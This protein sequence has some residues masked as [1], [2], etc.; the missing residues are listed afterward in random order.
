MTQEASLGLQGTADV[1]FSLPIVKAIYPD[2]LSNTAFVETIYQNVFNRPSDPEGSAYWTGLMDGG[3]SRGQLVMVMST[4][5]LGV[6]DGTAGKDYFQDRIDWAL[7][8]VAYQ[9][10]EQIELTPTHLLD[11]T[12]GVNADPMTAIIL[13]G[14]AEA[15][16]NI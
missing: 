11:L 7:Y 10:R 9:A 16:I 12:S 15:G 1:I 8:A 13:I 2:T 14:Q 3:W 4:A 6:P 5:A